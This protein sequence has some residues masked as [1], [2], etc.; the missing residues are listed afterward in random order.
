MLSSISSH[1]FLPFQAHQLGQNKSKA[2][3]TAF[4][5]VCTIIGL[6]RGGPISV[7]SCSEDAGGM[8][9]GG[10]VEEGEADEK[11]EDGM[12]CFLDGNEIVDD[13]NPSA[14]NIQRERREL[15]P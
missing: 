7:E 5:G 9:E 10:E 14:F 13:D 15:E 2:V 1:P 12:S 8:D 4:S 6:L 3:L 11:D